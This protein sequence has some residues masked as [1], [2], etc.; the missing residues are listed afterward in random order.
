MTQNS[1]YVV[2]VTIVDNEFQSQSCL[3]MNYTHDEALEYSEA[4]LSWGFT[5]QNAH[6]LGVKSWDIKPKLSPP[7]TPNPA[8]DDHCGQWIPIKTMTH[9]SLYWR[10]DIGTV[11][12]LWYVHIDLNSH[13]LCLKIWDLKQW[14]SP[15]MTQNSAY[16]VVVT[17]VDNEFQSQSCLTM[18]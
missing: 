5:H 7:M 2:V 13:N 1:A 14:L 6:H 3:T 11:K 4:I 17:L 18:N 10:W 15:S 9:H 16:V 12:L 8:C